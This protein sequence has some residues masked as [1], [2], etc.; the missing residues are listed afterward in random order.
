MK[1]FS[2][3]WLFVTLWTVAY[4]APLTMEFSRQEYWSGQPFPTPGDLPDTGIKPKPLSPALAGRFFSTSAT[5]EAGSLFTS[6]RMSYFFFH[7]WL[8]LGLSPRCMHNF[9][10]G[11]IPPQK[12]VDTFPLLLWG[13]ASSLLDPQ[14]AFL[15]MCRQERLPWPE[16]WAPYLL[17]LA[18][19]SFCHLLC[20]WECLGE[21]KTSILLHLTNT[22]SPAQGPIYLLPQL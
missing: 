2:H 21:N 16:K 3:V 18:E 12:P 9:L 11:W 6:S 13:E 1:S 10:L 5:W 7:I 22:S 19:L 8:V 17:T 20:P 15:H 4:Q 14:E